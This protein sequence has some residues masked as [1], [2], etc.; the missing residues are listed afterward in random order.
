MGREVRRVPL[1]FDWPLN[2]VWKGFLCPYRSAH[3][4]A[5]GGTGLNPAT[6]QISDD[7]YGLAKPKRRWV[8]A[9]TQD[10]V[11]A[12]VDEDRLG[13]F[14]HTFVQGQYVKKDPPYV[15]TAREVNAWSRQ[16]LGHDTVNQHIL[17]R[18]RAKRLGVYG[19]CEVC[20]GEGELWPDDDTRKKAEAWEP[21]PP[22]PGVGWQLWETVSEGSPISPVF[23]T[24][25]ELVD[26]LCANGYT[27][28]GAVELC[29]V[30][31]APS[32]ILKVYGTPKKPVN[33]NE[34]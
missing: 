33:L 15:P 21:E 12:L 31:S 10:E 22:P 9:I 28:R 25:N 11:Q 19:L 4:V 17:V 29:E 20:T 7:F 24:S 23:A 30:G 34:N 2:K 5:C 13:A 18:T 3:C 14:T 1:D 16:G 26:W 8:N 27:R 32:G 6:K